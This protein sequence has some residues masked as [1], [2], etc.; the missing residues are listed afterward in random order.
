MN[1]EK[2]KV[3]SFEVM[4]EVIHRTELTRAQYEQYAEQTEHV[5]SV[6]H[7]R[8]GVLLTHERVQKEGKGREPEPDEQWKDEIKENGENAMLIEKVCMTEAFLEKV[9]YEAA[10]DK[11]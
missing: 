1:A 8:V 2:R 3:A 11:Q 5:G 9:K 6:L 4:C 10:K 7:K